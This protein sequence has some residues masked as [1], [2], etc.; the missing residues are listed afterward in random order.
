M[1]K[2]IRYSWVL[3]YHAENILDNVFEKLLRVFLL[4]SEIFFST[5]GTFKSPKEKES[6]GCAQC[7]LPINMRMQFTHV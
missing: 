4:P 6:L 5:A 3:K 1:L 7:V 2:S